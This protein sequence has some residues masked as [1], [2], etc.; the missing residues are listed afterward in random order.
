[1]AYPRVMATLTKE[2]EARCIGEGAFSTNDLQFRSAFDAETHIGP[3]LCLASRTLHHH[4]PP[5]P[6][7]CSRKIY[8]DAYEEFALDNSTGAK[9]VSTPARHL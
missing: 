4:G 9:V 3:V 7:L 1:M 6:H 2:L 5:P 8:H